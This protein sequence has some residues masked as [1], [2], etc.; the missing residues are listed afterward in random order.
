MECE[1]SYTVYSGAKEEIPKNAPEPLGKFVRTTHYMDANLMHD[2][3]SGSSVSGILHFLNKTPIDWYSK[4][5][6]TVE[7]ATFGSE[8]VAAK[9]CTDQV[10]DLRLTL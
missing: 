8:Y 9:T 5:Q 3:I 4:L 2:L 10:V 7:T 1:W 6:A